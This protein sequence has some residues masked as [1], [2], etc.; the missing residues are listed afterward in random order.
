M[1]AVAGGPVARRSAGTLPL[2]ARRVLVPAQPHAPWMRAAGVP[3][4]QAR[5]EAGSPVATVA[6]ASIINDPRT[7]ME[8]SSE[9]RLFGPAIPFWSRRGWRARFPLMWRA[10]ALV[11]L[12]LVFCQAAYASL[13]SDTDGCADGCP[14]E[15]PDRQCSPDCA[16][17]ACC[18]G[19][20]PLVLVPV[21]APTAPLWNG[22]TLPET[23]AVVS[24][25]RPSEIFHVPRNRAL[26]PRQQPG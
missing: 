26:L 14:G 19:L 23:A 15:G 9:C 6:W 16:W 25:P 21:V 2:V 18:P 8:G 5:P 3:T 12:T 24:S 10:L 13:A 7:R 20:A 11:I 1:P 22:R 4:R 17:C